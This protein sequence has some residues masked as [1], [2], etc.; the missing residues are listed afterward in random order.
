MGGFIRRKSNDEDE[1]E[2]DILEKIRR[3]TPE[4]FNRLEN[5]ISNKTNVDDWGHTKRRILLSKPVK[6]VLNKRTEVFTTFISPYN[7]LS[8]LGGCGSM[9]YNTVCAQ[10]VP[11]WAQYGV[12]WR[13]AGIVIEIREWFWFGFKR[14]Y[15][16][17]YHLTTKCYA[18]GLYK[19]LSK[20]T[21]VGLRFYFFIEELFVF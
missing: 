12:I 2:Q 7:I 8:V 18:G 1:K 20:E 13:F 17:Q 16:N 11:T 3:E 4:R 15:T 14:V 10:R 21:K 5:K 6:E 9:R 19:Q